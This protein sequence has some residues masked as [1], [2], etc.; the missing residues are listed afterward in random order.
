MQW[1]SAQRPSATRLA[2]DRNTGA[3]ATAVF[4][5]TLGEELWK[6]FLPKFLQ[7]IGAPMAAIGGYGSL[8]DLVD[9]LAQYPG[10]WVSDQWGRKRA[11][12]SLTLLALLGYLV[13]ASASSWPLALAGI[14]L[15]MA[16]SSMA[17]PTLFAV[18][19]DALPSG[20]RVWGFTVQSI[21][22]RVPIAIAPV[23][24][25]I[26]IAGQGVRPGVRAGLMVAVGLALLTFAVLSLISLPRY[27]ATPTGVR[28]VWRMMATPLR[29]LLLSDI[30]IRCCEGLV[31]VLLVLYALDVV[32][33]SAPSYGS[34]VAVQMGT[35]I[36]AYVPGA[37]LV[38]RVGSKPVILLTFVAFALFPL[39]VV[40]ATS[41]A[42]L[43]LAFVVGGLR[44]LGEPA[45]KGLIVDLAR[46]EYRGRSVGLYYLIR[47][48]AISPAAAMGGLAWSRWPTLP[49]V[50]AGILG[51]A[52]TMA[53]ALTVEE[54]RRRRLTLERTDS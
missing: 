43:A 2:L 14:A 12:Q 22:R 3:V 27:S 7:E 18:I 48:V 49:F 21:L 42:G 50:A 8:R 47:S 9:G 36:L 17:S 31:D 5:M 53:F 46:P 15:T 40:A 29:R 41:Y 34:L 45:R 51:L 44:E 11:L 10:G 24:G 54:P 33:I 26:L 4:L 16:W 39:A 38:R 6:R 32:G 37:W 52:G 35:S 30:L 25:G 28:G 19:G 13:L 23:L 20:Q 1:V